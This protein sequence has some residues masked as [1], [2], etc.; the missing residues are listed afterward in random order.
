MDFN[1]EEYFVFQDKVILFSI[2]IEPG[3]SFR[4]NS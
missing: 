4:F 2:F 3:K 1:F